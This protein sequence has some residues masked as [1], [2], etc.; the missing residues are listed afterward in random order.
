[1]FPPR[2]AARASRRAPLLVTALLAGVLG[3]E[4][5]SAQDSRPMDLHLSYTQFTLENGLTVVVHREPALPIVAV[6]LWYH[7]G[8]ANERPGRTGFAHLFEHIMFEGSRHVPEGEFDTLLE[9]VGASANGSTSTDRTNYVEEVPSNALSLALW[10]ESDRM[11]WLLDTMDRSKLDIQREVV[12]N[13]R[14]QAYENQPYGLAWET[15]SAALYPP[16]HPYHWPVIGSM[17]DLEAATL[18]DVTR[19]FRTYYAP[20]NASLVVAGDV[21]V[22]QVRALAE[23]HFGAIP[24]GPDVPA[25][26]APDPTLRAPRVL[27]LEDDVQLPRLYMAWHSP[28][29]LTPGDAAMEL[30]ATVLANGRS[31]RLY[32]RLVYEEQVA[33]DVMAYQDEGRLGGAFH[34]VVTGRPEVPLSRLEAVVREELARLA[35]EGPGDDEVASARARAEADLVRSLDRLGGFDGRADRLN[36]YLFHTGD[37]GFIR[38]DLARYARLTAG[39]LADHA[40]SFLVERHGVTLSVVPRGRLEMAV[41]EGVR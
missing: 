18:D 8:S 41:P 15:L 34:L 10:L 25:V 4:A 6:N 29:A 14:R 35:S 12:K 24:R 1:M 11:G 5:L 37:P 17:E 39:D 40:R 21:R 2:T 9:S 16:E 33:Q 19:F 22:D 13:E 36:R 3:E 38:R 7:V 30:L 28:A 32:R 27:V 31:S 26:S 20:N 23:R